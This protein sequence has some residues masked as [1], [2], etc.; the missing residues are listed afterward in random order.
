MKKN[1]QA[2]TGSFLLSRNGKVHF[3]R[4]QN[5]VLTVSKQFEYFKNGSKVQS[6]LMIKTFAGKKLDHIEKN[7]SEYFGKKIKLCLS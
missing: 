6:I 7:I 5:N 2:L 1:N 4:Y 3:L